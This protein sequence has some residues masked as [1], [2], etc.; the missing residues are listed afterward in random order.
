MSKKQQK[1]GP[2]KLIGQRL[3]NNLKQCPVKKYKVLNAQ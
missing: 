3:V 1:I 2:P